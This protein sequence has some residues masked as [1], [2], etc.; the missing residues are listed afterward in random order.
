MSFNREK[1]DLC[2]TEQYVKDTTN[3]GL[4]G[5]NTPVICN[6]SFQTNPN[7]R[8]Q[9]SGASMNSGVNQRFGHGPVDVESELRNQNRMLGN[10]MENRYIPNSN[11]CECP[12]Q[13]HP[14]GQGVVDGCQTSRGP[15]LQDGQRC[16]DYNL[17]NNPDS[18]FPT[19]DTRLSNPP[20]T[21]RCTGINRMEPLIMNPQKRV[22]F[23]GEY[24]AQ[25]RMVMKDNHRP[26]IPNPAINDMSPSGL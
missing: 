22:I 16:G 23:P 11:D 17:T 12:S 18:Y 21:L 15:Q 6:Q 7:I 24:Q 2:S 9:R 5:L 19:E 25:T 3:V 1:Y 26:C 10:C 20:A 4:Y 8:M 14:A 13:G